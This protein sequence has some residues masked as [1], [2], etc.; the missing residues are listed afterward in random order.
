MQ[1]VQDMV[2]S[3]TQSRALRSGNASKL[4]GML[5]FLESGMFGRAG[6]GVLQA[7]KNCQLQRGEHLT[8]ELEESLNVIQAM[9][10]TKP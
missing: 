1:K 3:I 7:I 9:L 8:P 5:N 2:K 10:A 6:A 4:Y